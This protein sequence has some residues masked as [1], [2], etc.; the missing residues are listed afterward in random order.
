L[1]KVLGYT[2]IEHSDD[3]STK[4][5]NKV[6][7]DKM[8]ALVSE[9]GGRPARGGKYTY[10]NADECPD[11]GPWKGVPAGVSKKTGK[12]YNAFY[13]CEDDECVNRPTKEWVETHPVGGVAPDQQAP[14][15]PNSAPKESAA[16][17][18]DL[19]F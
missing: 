5:I 15:E 2:V 17:F 13:T 7:L 8:T 6:S 4:V 10:L 12:P 3:G 14:P 1:S 9:M 18:D 11:H 19:P 16:D